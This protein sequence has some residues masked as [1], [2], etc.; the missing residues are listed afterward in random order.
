LG[1]KVTVEHYE[2]PYCETIAD[3]EHHPK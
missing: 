1:L 2:R 3:D